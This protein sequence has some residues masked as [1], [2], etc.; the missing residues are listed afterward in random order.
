MEGLPVKPA[1]TGWEA[2]SQLFIKKIYI[3][4]SKS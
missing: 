3:K 1:S 2:F 4:I